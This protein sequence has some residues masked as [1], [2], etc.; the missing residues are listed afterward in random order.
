MEACSAKV[1]GATA[2][3]ISGNTSIMSLHQVSILWKFRIG[4]M[5]LWV[6]IV[7]TIMV[8]RNCLLFSKLRIIQ[9]LLWIAFH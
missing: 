8:N 5:Y 1:S 9:E 4:I 7:Y 2:F 3:E 6:G